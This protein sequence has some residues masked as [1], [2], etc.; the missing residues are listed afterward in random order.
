MKLNAKVT[1]TERDKERG[2]LITGNIEGGGYFFKVANAD[3]Y[4]LDDELVMLILTKEQAAA[5]YDH[6]IGNGADP[7][8]LD[9]VINQLRPD[10]PESAEA[11]NA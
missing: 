5:A 1:G 10:A 9:K 3:G 2:V 8:V 7:I 11:A 4:A 6:L